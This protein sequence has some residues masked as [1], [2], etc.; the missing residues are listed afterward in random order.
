VN[1]LFQEATELLVVPLPSV[2]A[3]GLTSRVML[4]QDGQVVSREV[5]VGP[6]G[7]DAWPVHRGLSDSDL[8]ILDPAG[9]QEGQRVRTTVRSFRP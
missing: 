9:V 7:R 2:L 5:E 3:Q 8:V 4:V 6:A 1:I